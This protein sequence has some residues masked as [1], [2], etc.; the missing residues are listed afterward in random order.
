M[1]G[2]LAR[3]LILPGN[4]TS[5][6]VLLLHSPAYNIIFGTKILNKLFLSQL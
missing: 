4:V 3:K 1:L 6:H 2:K 5:V